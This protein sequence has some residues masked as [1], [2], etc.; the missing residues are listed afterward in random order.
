MLRFHRRLVLPLVAVSLLPAAVPAAAD[1]PKPDEYTGEQLLGRMSMVYATCKT[2]RDTG[3]VKSDIVHALG[4]TT[5]NKP[6]ET[7][8]IRPDRFRFEFSRGTPKTNRYLVWSKGKDVQTWWYLKPGVNKPASLNMAL[9]GPTG[10]SGGSAHT[11]PALLMPTA[12][13]GNRIS[14]MTDAKRLADA[15]H[16]NADCFR[17]EGMYGNIPHTVWLDKKTFLILRIDSQPPIP[18]AQVE[19]TT[20]YEPVINGEISESLLAFDPPK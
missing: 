5:E 6:F 19:V 9:A 10:V 16:N 4:K 2:Y 3:I 14:K 7:A 20:T 15:K 13:Q 18:N 17:V 11:V 1:E 8:F 12:V